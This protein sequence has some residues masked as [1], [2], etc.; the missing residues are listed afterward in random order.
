VF[1]IYQGRLP[2]ACRTVLDARAAL[3]VLLW[4]AGLLILSWLGRYNGT[5]PTVFG[6]SMV[7]RQV[8]PNWWD[9]AAVG[10]FSLVIYYWAVH[11]TLPHQRISA[12]VEDVETEA[13]V[14][15]EKSL[16]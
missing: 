7:A 14:E 2:K 10:A 5:P 16:A 11:S 9:L 3:W 15:L 12:E 6:I 1:A 8:L 4:L 13:S